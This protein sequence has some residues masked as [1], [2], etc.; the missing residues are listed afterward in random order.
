M[1]VSYDFSKKRKRIIDTL[2]L[3]F[4]RPEYLKRDLIEKAKN[5]PSPSLE[6]PESLIKF[7]VNVQNGVVI[8]Q[9]LNRPEYIKN[10]ELIWNLEA[11]MP[12]ILKFMCSDYILTLEKP[13]YEITLED[14]GNWLT[15]KANAMS[16]N[17]SYQK[18]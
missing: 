2:E 17:V 11:K 9:N 14:F 15:I 7:S 4:G 18:L 3:R 10:P 5:T 12:P 13:S 16:R 6:D 8:L 1:S